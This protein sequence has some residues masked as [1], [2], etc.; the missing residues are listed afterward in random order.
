[1]KMYIGIKIYPTKF[2]HKSQ[3]YLVVSSLFYVKSFSDSINWIS[4][5]NL[6]PE[7]SNFSNHH[8]DKN[9]CRSLTWFIPSFLGIGG[10]DDL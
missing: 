4:G 3:Y 2:G 5:V 1:M 9:L 8:F 7:N 10:V 6:D